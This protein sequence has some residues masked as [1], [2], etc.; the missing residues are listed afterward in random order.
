MQLSKS[1]IFVALLAVV[2]NVAA[3]S[4][5]LSYEDAEI[6]ASSTHLRI[7]GDSYVFDKSCKPGQGDATTT[8]YLE[9]KKNISFKNG[10]SVHSGDSCTIT[11][12]WYNVPKS[13]N[14]GKNTQIY[15]PFK[16]MKEVRCNKDGSKHSTKKSKTTTKKKTTTKRK[17]STKKKTTKKKTSTKKKTTKRKTTAAS[18]S[19]GYQGKA[20][21]FTP[22]QGA[23]GDWNDNNDLIAAISGSLYGSF[24]KKSSYCDR[25]VRVTNKDNGKSVTVTVKD[26]CPSCDKSHI[27]L[28][29]AAFGQ[30][31]A[32][33]KGIL[34]VQWNFL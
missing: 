5:K 33:D 21:F 32:F 10:K 4:C 16:S 15:I 26:G 19:G 14:S 8:I 7:R 27:D 24:S 22:N 3:K 20:T 13:Y 34:K 29:P 18:S 23:C 1:C 30:I 31:G 11:A 12:K 6:K 2:G 25:K 9:T 17:S 28:S